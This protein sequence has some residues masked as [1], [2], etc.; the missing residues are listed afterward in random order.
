MAQVAVVAAHALCFVAGDAGVGIHA[1]EDAG[2]VDVLPPI[3]GVGDDF[4]AVLAYGVGDA[5]GAVGL[6]FVEGVE[7]VLAQDALLVRRLV[8]SSRAV[9]QVGVDVD[10]GLGRDGGE[11]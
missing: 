5:F 9:P 7:S 1:E 4:E 8:L 10:F 11:G 3:S 2:G 6:T